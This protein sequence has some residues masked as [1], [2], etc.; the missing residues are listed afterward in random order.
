V[1]DHPF[2]Y[3]CPGGT[4]CAV[5]GEDHRA[6]GARRPSLLER[7]AY[8]NGV[9]DALAAALAALDGHGLNDTAHDRIKRLRACVECDHQPEQHGPEGTCTM[10][11]GFPGRGYPCPCA[12][13]DQR[14][15]PKQRSGR[16]V[17]PDPS[18]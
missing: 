8:D 11:V 2:K 12:D 4:L 17:P 14:V 7:I 3:A 6:D 18:S 15:L 5:C 1:A 9:Y 13:Y 10:L 16:L